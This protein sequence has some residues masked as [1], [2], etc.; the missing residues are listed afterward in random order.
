LPSQSG[1]Y[2]VTATFPITVPNNN[3]GPT[4]NETSTTL[5]RNVTVNALPT[6]SI[7]GN[8]TVCPGSTN[9]YTGSAGMSSYQWSII[10]SGSIS[11][12]STNPSVN[13]VAGSTCG[14]YTLTLAITDGN[15][16]SNTCNQTINITDNTAPSISA[17]GN[18]LNAWL[19]SNSFRY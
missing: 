5:T 4:C 2:Q 15:G 3:G 7:T 16:C 13:V 17:T 12:L 19:Q 1:S 10:G 6:C 11:G 18:S 14:S 9:V 8:N